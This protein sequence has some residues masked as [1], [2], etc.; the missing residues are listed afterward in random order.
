MTGG[1]SGDPALP[2]GPE[3]AFEPNTGEENDGASGAPQE[4][5]QVPSPVDF[6]R[7]VLNVNLWSK[8]EEVLAALP[9]NRRVAVK[10]GNGLGKGFC[11]AVAV[12]WFLHYHDPAIVLSTA[13]T[14]RQVSC[15]VAPRKSWTG[16]YWT[17]GG[18]WR[19]TGM[20]WDFPP[21]PPTSFKDSTA[22][23]CSSWWTRRKG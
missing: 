12:L 5:D 22:Q 1:Q 20:H 7:E 21:I 19:K 8:Q 17:L 6:A 9:L 18:N 11:A 13:P 4:Q 3:Q 2:P 23:T 10:S 14:F 16:R 15:T